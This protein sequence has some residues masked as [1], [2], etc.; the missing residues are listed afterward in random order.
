MMRSRL[1]SVCAFFI[2]FGSPPAL[3]QNSSQ[4]AV[5]KALDKPAAKRRA[6]KKDSGP[7]IRSEAFFRKRTK[8]LVNEKWRQLFKKLKKIIAVTPDND[9]AKPELYYRLSELFR[10]RAAAISIAA[11]EQEDVCLSSANSEA[12]QVACEE[13]K[14]RTVQSSQQYRDKAIDLYM[15]IAKNFGDYPRLDNVLYTRVQLSAGDPDSQRK[16]SH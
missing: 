2:I 3:T 10:E 16:L 6:A 1:L 11:Y 5:P 8:T 15:Y 4:R 13:K 14:T 9:P 12:A 7:N